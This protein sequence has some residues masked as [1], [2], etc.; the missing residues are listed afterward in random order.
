[1]SPEICTPEE[2][3]ASI[4]ELITQGTPTTIKNIAEDICLSEAVTLKLCLNLIEKGMLTL[5]DDGRR[6]LLT[7]RGVKASL[8]ATG[9]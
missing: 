9:W 1:M 6:F 4:T 7:H 5:R 2:V 8:D 3:L